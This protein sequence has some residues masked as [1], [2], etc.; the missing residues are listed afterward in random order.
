MDKK[1]VSIQRFP[2]ETL[3]KIQEEHLQ[4][5]LLLEVKLKALQHKDMCD[6]LIS[7]AVIKLKSSYGLSWQD[8]AQSI[9]GITARGHAYKLAH[10]KVGC[11]RV[12]Y[13]LIS[14]SIND[15]LISM[16][17]KPIDFPPYDLSPTILATPDAL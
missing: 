6:L 14:A 4:R 1:R 5:Q 7:G 3:R 10:R 13:Q 17:D 9:H 2:P 15:F 12:S 16:G 8:I 11:S